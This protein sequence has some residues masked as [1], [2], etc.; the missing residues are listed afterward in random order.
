MTAAGERAK[1]KPTGVEFK[2]P[3]SGYLMYVTEGPYKGWIVALHLDGQWV[4]LFDTNK[5]QKQNRRAGE[6]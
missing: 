5:Y 4:T 1:F 3:Y 2:N 6:E